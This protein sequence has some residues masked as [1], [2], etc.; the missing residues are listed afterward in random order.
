MAE[1][2]KFWFWFVIQTEYMVDMKCEGCVNSVKNKLQTVDG[3]LFWASALQAETFASFMPPSF[4]QFI[5]CCSCSIGFLLGVKS[6]E[7][8]LNSQVVRIL[9]STPVKTMTEALEQT[10]RKARLIGQGIPEG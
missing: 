2:L 4:W 3:K 7:V 5:L 1:K 8:D 9:G 10:G 6:V